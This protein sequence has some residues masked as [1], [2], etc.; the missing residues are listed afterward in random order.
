MKK[1]IYSIIIAVVLMLSSLAAPTKVSALEIPYRVDVTKYTS[2]EANASAQIREQVKAHANTV[3]VYVRTKDKDLY[4]VFNRIWNN[5]FAETTN[6]DEGDYLYWQMSSMAASYNALMRKE[7]GS[8]TYYTKYTINVDYFISLEQEQMLT[9]ELNIIN[10]SFGFTETT[11]DYEKVKTIYDY[12]CHNVT[13]DYSDN[14]MKFTAY[15]AVTT[16]K[17][18]C[19][20][21]A[22]LFYRLAKMQGISSR[23]IA[24]HGTNTDVYHGWNIVKLGNLYYNVDATWDAAN[25]KLGH[26]YE[27]FLKGDVFED[28]TRTDDYKTKNFYAAYPMAADDYVE[29]VEA[30]ASAETVNS[31]FTMNKTSIKKLTRN[32]IS[33]NKIAEAT[34]YE[35]QYSTNKKFASKKKMTTT[36]TT[37][38]FRKLS[39]KKTYYFRVRGY[40]EAGSGKIYTKWSTVKKI[41]KIKK[42]KK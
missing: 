16:G 29:G 12:I 23:V 30:V 3:T 41:K 19:Q 5:A 4:A 31:T 36:K 27:Y 11:T 24:G 14:N 20:G 10:E 18:V 40:R 17:S 38:K 25:Y 22:T 32:K 21:Y 8:N 9:Q 37:C 7:K 35:I 6:P 13:Y 26:P 39:K 34:G 33:F 1:R 15:A 28:H 2:D 42:I